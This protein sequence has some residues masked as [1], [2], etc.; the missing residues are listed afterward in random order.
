VNVELLAVDAGA[1][2]TARPLGNDLGGV[3]ERV[4]PRGRGER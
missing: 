3:C 2:A 4:S 1:S